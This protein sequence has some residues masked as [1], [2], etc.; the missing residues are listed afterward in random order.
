MAV[1]VLPEDL[2]EDDNWG[3]C[4]DFEE[5]SWSS[6]SR[7][8]SQSSG[9]GSKKQPWWVKAEASAQAKAKSFEGP[10]AGDATVTPPWWP[11]GGYGGAPTMSA[12]YAS[13]SGYGTSGVPRAP[14]FWQVPSSRPPVDGPFAGESDFNS[15]PSMP[16]MTSGMGCMGHPE[17]LPMMSFVSAPPPP[18]LDDFEVQIVR[19]AHPWSRTKSHEGSQDDAPA[20]SEEVGHGSSENKQDKDQ[21]KSKGSQKTRSSQ[22]KTDS[23]QEAKDDVSTEIQLALAQEGTIL[24]KSDFDAGVRRYLGAL[25]GCQNGQQKVK[26]AMHMIKTYTGAKSRESVKNWP[27][28]L[29]TLLKRFEPDVFNLHLQQRKGGGKGKEPRTREANKIRKPDTP[30]MTTPSPATPKSPTKEASS[31]SRAAA[32]T[33][34]PAKKA[35]EDDTQPVVPA[36][37]LAQVLPSN[38]QEGRAPL[39]QELRLAL[40]S[41]KCPF[42]GNTLNLEATLV[43]NLASG[44]ESALTTQTSALCVRHALG[45]AGTREMA[46]CPRA[47]DAAAFAEDEKA[48]T[49]PDDATA[50]QAV[51]IVASSAR[52]RP[53][54]AIAALSKTIY[55]EIGLEVLADVLRNP[56]LTSLAKA[57]A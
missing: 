23:R 8:N 55:E 6:E 2:S 51:R 26:E 40:S 33:P 16:S 27:A 56:R 11:G 35:E 24:V 22:E 7:W 32:S 43:S 39:L 46:E 9:W 44:I 20:H 12:G 41:P 3:T 30:E 5:S 53:G 15:F 25:H 50:E 14:G 57:G 49:L 28:Y 17:A 29:L 10:F 4:W 37:E 45:V 19:K 38:W 36:V 42:T 54:S 21:G 52:R 13:Y 34:Q 31:S 18:S 47:G 1:D 48:S